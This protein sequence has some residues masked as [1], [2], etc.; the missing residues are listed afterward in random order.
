MTLTNLIGDYVRKLIRKK[1]PVHI[2]L[3][4]HKILFIPLNI[5]SYNKYQHGVAKSSTINTATKRT[6]PYTSDPS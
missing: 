3:P 5:V 1:S 2:I 4:V 6:Y